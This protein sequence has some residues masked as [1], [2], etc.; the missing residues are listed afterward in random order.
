MII[1]C[2][3]TGILRHFGVSLANPANESGVDSLL[4]GRAAL[5]LFPGVKFVVSVEFANKN[6][7]ERIRILTVNNQLPSQGSA[8][9]PAAVIASLSILLT[10]GLGVLGILSRVNMVVGK[11]VAQGKAAASVPQ[12]L[13]DWV[14]GSATVIFAFGISWVLLSVRGGWRGLLLWMTSMVL[15]AGW[16]PVLELAAYSPDIGA[17]WIA[18]LWSGICALVYAKNHQMLPRISPPNESHETR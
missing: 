1:R 3:R 14:V 5:G 8:L 17:P 10:A 15:L 12:V 4:T 2:P 18:V 16:A 7:I 6:F 11:M 13:P 9:L